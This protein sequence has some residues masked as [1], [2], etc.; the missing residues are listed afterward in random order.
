MNSM[1]SRTLKA[2]CIVS[3]AA[4]L[5]A[6]GGASTTVNSFKPV[7]VIGFGDAYNDVG[8][9]TGAPFTVRGSG[10]VQ[11]VVEQVAAYF[12][13]G[14]VGTPVLDTTFN[15]TTNKIPSFGVFSYAMGNALIT[16]NTAVTTD[17]SLTEQIDRVLADVGTFD[18]SQDLI[19]LSIG[20]RDVR[21]GVDKDTAVNDLMTQLQ[22]LLDANARH[23]LVMPPLERSGGT[24]ASQTLAFANALSGKLYD[25]LVRAPYQGN[26]IILAS[27]PN[28]ALLTNFNIYTS[29][30]TYSVFTTSTTVAYCP[31]PTVLTGCAVGDGDGTTYT[32]RLFADNLNLTPA[33]NQWVALQLYSATAQGWR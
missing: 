7:R 10:A 23:I 1:F 25:L 6:C 20:T 18:S 19:I 30:A 31:N 9:A 2:L 3:T 17:V 26:P 28:P 24:Y 27:G 33:G 5:S 16:A 8:L 12:G 14:A 15:T 22:R 29:S 11:T 4:L 13:V 32:T 21:A